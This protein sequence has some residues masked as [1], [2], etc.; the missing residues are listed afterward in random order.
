M[1]MADMKC[2]NCGKPV[3][4][5][6]EYCPAC[7]EQVGNEDDDTN[8]GNC[9]EPV[10]QPME[11]CPACGE[12]IGEDDTEAG[13]RDDG[14]PWK[15]HGEVEPTESQEGYSSAVVVGVAI[16]AVVVGLVVG[17][18]FAMD[19]ATTSVIDCY[20]THIANELRPSGQGFATCL[21]NEGMSIRV[22]E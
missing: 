9:G 16:A 12:Q 13:Q 15:Q 14:V 20:N 10:A 1:G 21:Q 2:S 17:Y 19:S 4:Q 18:Y 5:D 22:P 8:C 6:M 7:G 3:T 11:Y